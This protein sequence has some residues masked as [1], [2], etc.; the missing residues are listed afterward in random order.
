MTRYAPQGALACLALASMFMMMRIVRKSATN[1]PPIPEDPTADHDL[2]EDEESD[3]I[4]AV[5]AGAVGQAQLG[6]SFLT[7]KELDEEMLHEIQMTSEV[8]RMVVRESFHSSG[9]SKG[10]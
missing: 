9:E 1:M 3:E 7:A 8:A 2:E 6:D 4:L 5:G 10:V